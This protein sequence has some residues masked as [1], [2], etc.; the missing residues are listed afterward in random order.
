MINVE[1]DSKKKA[2]KVTASG[3]LKAD[4]VNSYLNELQEIVKKIDPSQYALIIDAREQ[5]AIAPDALPCLEKA[6]KLYTE[7]PFAKRFSVVLESAVAMQQVKRVGKDEVDQFIMVTSVEEV[8][9]N[10]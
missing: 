6:L 9:K 5:K 8:Y 4:E 10:L 3:M 2:V 7:I 1:L